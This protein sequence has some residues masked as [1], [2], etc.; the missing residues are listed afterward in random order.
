[1]N[2]VTTADV[3]V[4]RSAFDRLHVLCDPRGHDLLDALESVCV[5]AV[6]AFGSVHA[7]VL[8]MGHQD[9]VRQAERRLKR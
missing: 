5:E 6:S 9:R 8:E 3:A 2:V 7:A 1:M 4:V